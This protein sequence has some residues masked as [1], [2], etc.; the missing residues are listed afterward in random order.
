MAVLRTILVA[1]VFFAALFGL[2]PFVF[3]AFVLSFIGLKKP[4]TLFIY[5]LA[6]ITARLMIFCTGCPLDIKGRENIPQD[7]GVCFVSNHVGI[8]DIVLAAAFIGRPFG[9]VAKKELLYV[10]FLNLWIWLLGGLFIDRKNLKK[11]HHTINEGVKRIKNGGGMIIFPEGTRSRGRGLQPFRSGAFKLAT[12]ADAVIVPMTISGT[13]DLFERTG[14]VQKALIDV[15]FG[16]AIPTAD[17]PHEERKQVL[18]DNVHEIIRGALK[19]TQLK[20]LNK[21][22]R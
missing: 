15:V 5:K 8:F 14:L 9:F 21:L 4:M 22:N 17:I 2:L 20:D 16:K 11:A 10:P 1:L 13:Y 12:Q 18:S 6:Q 7:K 3:L 19:T